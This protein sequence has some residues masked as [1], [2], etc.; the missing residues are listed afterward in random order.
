MADRVGMQTAI[1]LRSN[2]L[3]AAID[4]SRQLGQRARACEAERL[5]R[6][7]WSV[8]A[9]AALAR[10][11]LAVVTSLLASELLPAVGEA[12]EALGAAVSL[13][14]TPPR[15]RQGAWSVE[16]LPR[17]DRIMQRH[18]RACDVL[19]VAERRSEALLGGPPPLYRDRDG[20][21][22]VLARVFDDVE[23]DRQ[24]RD[25]WP[26]VEERLNQAL[27]GLVEPVDALV[28]RL[29]ADDLDGVPLVPLKRA[30]LGAYEDLCEA[31]LFALARLDL[32]PA[33]A[34]RRARATA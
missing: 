2:P 26:G 20:A 14:G 27:C 34:H 5:S 30:M 28:E 29:D 23:L 18:R 3:S 16:L 19:V 32:E 10:G 21:S 17:L 7:L 6:T 11:H 24:G 12:M 31:F 1:P 15:E 13:V 9:E 33:W 8:T 22:R 4:W 25:A